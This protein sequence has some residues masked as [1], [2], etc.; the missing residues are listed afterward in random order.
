[1]TITILA[2]TI[3]D[4]FETTSQEYFDIKTFIRSKIDNQRLDRSLKLDIALLVDFPHLSPSQKIKFAGLACQ[5][6]HQQTFRKLALQLAP[7]LVAPKTS[8]TSAKMKEI[9]TLRFPNLVE[10]LEKE[11]R[12]DFSSSIR[13][14]Q[15]KIKTIFAVWLKTIQTPQQMAAMAHKP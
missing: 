15:D 13:I 8:K 5:Q 1:M 2:C 7:V 12:A 6:S 3:W 10:L 14:R 11:T 9:S 4:L